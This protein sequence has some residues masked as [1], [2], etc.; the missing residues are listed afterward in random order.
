MGNDNPNPGDYRY[1]P[2]AYQ[3]G[4]VT[5]SW[6]SSPYT[7]TMSIKAVGDYTLKVVFKKEVYNNGSWVA[8]GTSD[9]KSVTFRVVKGA[10]GVNT[11]D[12]TNLFTPL[13]IAGI[14]LGVFLICLIVFLIIF[15]RRRRR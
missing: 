4:N 2:A 11:G 10:A 7:T 6:N 3:I 15:I 5:G 9:T 14:S 1:R 12:D 13:L 8:D